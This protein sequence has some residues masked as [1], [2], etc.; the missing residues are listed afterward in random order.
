MAE[1]NRETSMKEALGGMDPFDAPIPGSSL[2]NPKETP[3]PY[4]TTPNMN[5]PEEVTAGIWERIRDSE[6]ALDG[7]LDSMRDG[8]PL[9][10]IAQVLLFEGFRQ[11]EYNPD[12][13]LLSIE[14]TIYLLA[15][16]ANWAEIP[17]EIYPEEEMET[18]PVT[19]E[20]LDKILAG[21]EGEELPDSV[22]LGETT[23]QRPSS[24]PA[25]L[26]NGDELPNKESE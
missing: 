4:E 21:M 20:V 18:D 10:D 15:F 25:S 16:L 11:G 26:L 1:M 7:V 2:T 24:V 6:E 5:T 14:P 9:E 13:M 8:V 17:A 22:T 23:L 19:G 3:A 12:V